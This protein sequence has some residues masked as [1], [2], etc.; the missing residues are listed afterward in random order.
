L[1]AFWHFKL[2]S[3]QVKYFNPKRKGGLKY[4]ASTQEI[5]QGTSERNVRQVLAGV[6]KKESSRR[7]VGNKKEMISKIFKTMRLV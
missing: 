3:G 1:Y 2:K 5:Q 4:G 7:V 6:T